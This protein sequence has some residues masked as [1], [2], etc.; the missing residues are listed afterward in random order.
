MTI[1]GPSVPRSCS[2]SII[3]VYRQHSWKLAAV[4]VLS[5]HSCY[6]RII[7]GRGG[8]LESSRDYVQTA[9]HV[10]MSGRGAGKCHWSVD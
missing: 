8:A 10:R 2:V 7:G 5:Q 4:D 3:R 9:R 6:V 1:H